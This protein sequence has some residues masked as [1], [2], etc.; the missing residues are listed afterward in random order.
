[1]HLRHGRA[2]GHTKQCESSDGLQDTEISR[3]QN[4]P[5]VNQSRTL[6]VSS[7]M[8]IVILGWSYTTKWGLSASVFSETDQLKVSSAAYICSDLAVIPLVE[9]A[10]GFFPA[11]TCI[12]L[13]ICEPSAI[14]RPEAQICC[15]PL[16]P[17]PGGPFWSSTVVANSSRSMQSSSVDILPYQSDGRRVSTTR[18][19]K[20]FS[21]NI[22]GSLPT[23]LHQNV[24]QPVF[25]LRI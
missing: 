9:V 13:D 7:H 10:S 8:G 11:T 16:S 20:P 18:D 23:Q 3:E 17:L 5:W 25:P 12:R 22:S 24:G 2:A 14:S 6:Y 1:M 19:W 15:L 4:L 21:L